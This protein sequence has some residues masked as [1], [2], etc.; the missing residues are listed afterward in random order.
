[1]A[2]HRRTA[3]SDS[4]VSFPPPYE[5]SDDRPN[6]LNSSPLR[7]RRP[8]SAPILLSQREPSSSPPAYL[9]T[10]S[11]GQ[12]GP[13]VEESDET[14]DVV[15]SIDPLNAPERPNVSGGIHHPRVAV[16]LGVNSHWHKWLF[17]CRLLC[18]LPELSYG[19][20]LLWQIHRHAWALLKVKE[21]RS[22]EIWMH[23]ALTRSPTI[24]SAERFDDTSTLLE[25]ILAAV[26]VSMPLSS[27]L[28]DT[29]T[30][31]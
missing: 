30:Q 6:D 3:S 12:Y 21:Q 8:T 7:G 15:A 14:E 17:I 22:S 29:S 4:N 10:V 26:W 24:P 19:I 2:R 1:M 23:L 27:G 9:N 5:S 28:Y 11:L 31:D 18:V 13:Y 16:L 25:L 20:P